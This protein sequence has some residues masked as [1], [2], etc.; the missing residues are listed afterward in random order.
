MKPEKKESKMKKSIEQIIEKF[1][2]K[3]IQVEKV[4]SRASM[5]RKIKGVLL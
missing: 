1:R 4:L 5:T 3:G 2:K